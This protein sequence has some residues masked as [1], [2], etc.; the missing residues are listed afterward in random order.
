MLTDVRKK[1][2]E[3]VEERVPEEIHF[4]SN[5]GPPIGLLQETKMALTEALHKGNILMLRETSSLQNPKRKATEV[6]EAKSSVD[7]N[8]PEPQA[9]KAGGKA[10]ECSATSVP[11]ETKHVFPSTST[12]W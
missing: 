11:S 12:E 2:R 1:I 10:P 9:G 8:I 3:E 7:V 4:L 6:E 5:W